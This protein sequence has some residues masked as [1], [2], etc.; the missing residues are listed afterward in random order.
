VIGQSKMPIKKGKKIELW[1]SPP[2]FFLLDD[3]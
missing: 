3:L 1:R 2:K